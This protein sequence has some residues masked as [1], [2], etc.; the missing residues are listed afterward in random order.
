M[1][2]VAFITGASRG[3]GKAVAHKLASEGWDIVVAAKSTEEHPKLPGTIFTAAGVPH[4]PRFPPDAF[5]LIMERPR[6]DAGGRAGGTG[7]RARG[8]QSAGPGQ[9]PSKSRKMA[10]TAMPAS[11]VASKFFVARLTASATAVPQM[12]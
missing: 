11:N 2:K 7:A 5:V 12:K 10:T 3:I 6:R 4:S 9:A 8:R 1:N